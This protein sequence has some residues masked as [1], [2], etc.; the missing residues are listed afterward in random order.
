MSSLSYSFPAKEGEVCWTEKEAPVK[1]EDEEVD[2][3]VKQEGEEEAV[4]VKEEEDAFRVKEEED[5]VYGVKEE[6]ET[7]YLGPVSQTHLNKASSG[8]NDEFSHKMVLRN[9]SLINTKGAARQHNLARG[10]RSS[11][12]PGQREPLVNTTWPEGAARQH[13]L[14]RGSR[15]ST[16]PGQREPLVNTTWPDGAPPPLLDFV[17]SAVLLLKFAD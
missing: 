3:S 14:A 9:R 6:E 5:A 16:Q 17:N 15:S 4:T 11:T 10:S 8:S 2:I 1:E 12:Q 7:G 13:N